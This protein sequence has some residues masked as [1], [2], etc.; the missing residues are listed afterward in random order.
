MPTFKNAASAVDNNRL[1]T[2]LNEDKSNTFSH[3]APIRETSWRNN[4]N[5]H[6]S[7]STAMTDDYSTSLVTNNM[8]N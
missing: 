1:L 4:A 5:E 3:I 8:A 2:D 6:V 7:P